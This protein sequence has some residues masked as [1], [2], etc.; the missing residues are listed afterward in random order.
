MFKEK[1]FWQELLKIFTIKNRKKIRS[2]KI[3]QGRK[4]NVKQI[5]PIIRLS[6]S[7]DY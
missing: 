4:A 5:Y 7:L 1:E 6:I 3:R 2:I